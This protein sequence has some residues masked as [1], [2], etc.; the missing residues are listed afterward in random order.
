[1]E[2]YASN[3]GYEIVEEEW[4]EWPGL[5]LRVFK[6]RPANLVDLLEG[7][8]RR[9]PDREG[10]I[11]GDVRL[12]FRQ[13]DDM[14][15][16]IAAG[17]QESGVRKG[18]RIALLLGIGIEF[19]VSF[20]ALMKL[21]AIAVPL[22]TR[23][24]GEEMAYEIDHSE[25]R[26]LILDEENW[27]HFDSV[28]DRLKTVE[29]VYYN[30]S[31]PPAGTIPFSTLTNTARDTFERPALSET[32]TATILYTSGTTGKPKGAMLHH[33]GFALSAMQVSDFLSYTM[34][35]RVICC[36][37][38]FHATGLGL[39]V[40]P[41]LLV[42][43]ATV[44]LRTFKV[45]EFLEVVAKERVTCFKGV[46]TV[47]WLMINHPDF[48]R[49]DFSS[50]RISVPGGSAAT[51]E[52]IKRIRSKLPNL[53][54][55]MG[56]GMTETVGFDT[57]VPFDEVGKEITCVG[58]MLPIV[59]VCI[60]D[61]NG[62]QLPK[63]EVGEIAFKS[64]K[65][66]RGYWKNPEATAAA[67]TDGWFRSGDLGRMD[68]R[69]LIYLLDRK[70]DMINRGGEKIYSREVENVIS[71]H[72]KVLEVAVVAAPDTMLGEVVKAVI[73]PRLEEEVSGEEIIHFC[74]DRLADFKVPRY[75]EF[76][77]SLPRNP[78]G[79]VIKGELRYIPSGAK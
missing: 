9:Y 50:F 49:Y 4:R 56:Y 58:R 69:D 34:D 26:M 6:D 54:L 44:F 53:T 22:N 27:V 73:V 70:K 29:K 39:V 45:K 42:G 59:D 28:R 68:E 79:K 15:N 66:S 40:I 77:E 30:G 38:L 72:P 17:L 11:A 65:N 71:D 25:S 32:D 74:A 1:M 37:P 57:V 78:A 46:I 36:V 20:F 76:M 19:M 55:S 33:L 60:L 14:A 10:F 8:A 18:D 47:L 63:G 48:D 5:R 23:F 31:N 43:A 21:G 2:R 67:I 61:D 51:E 75:V 16:R 41:A 7:T 35:D 12:T 3:S 52:Q 62:R 24:K 64:A 13:F